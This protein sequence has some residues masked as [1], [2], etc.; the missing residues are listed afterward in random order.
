MFS[1]FRPTYMPTNSKH[2]Q[3]AEVVPAVE[4]GYHC[5]ETQGDSRVA[6]GCF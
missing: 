5:H 1:F 2:H 3:E 4:S 6:G